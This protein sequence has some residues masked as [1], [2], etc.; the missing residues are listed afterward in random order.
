MASVLAA[1]VTSDA[2]AVVAC[3]DCGRDGGI[4]GDHVRSGDL[5]RYGLDSPVRSYI[6]HEGNFVLS[7]GTEGVIR[8][9]ARTTGLATVPAKYTNH[10]RD[11]GDPHKCGEHIGRSG[12]TV[13]D[14]RSIFSTLSM[15]HDL[16][17]QSSTGIALRPIVIG[18]CTVNYRDVPVFTGQVRSS[19]WIRL[20]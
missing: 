6:T 20:T 16:S 18:R 3:S 8:W 11:T 15:H 17:I 4:H 5:S 14:R 12:R 10:S 2:K 7:I 13:F 19:L 1:A 9:R